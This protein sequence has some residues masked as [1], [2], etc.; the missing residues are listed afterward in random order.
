MPQNHVSPL[1]A[2]LA[3]ARAG[4]TFGEASRSATPRAVGT[5]EHQR[6][7]HLEADR[8]AIAPTGEPEVGRL[9]RYTV[10]TSGSVGE[11]CPYMASGQ[12]VANE[13][14]EIDRLRVRATP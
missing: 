12:T 10:G 8:S 11:E 6:L 4:W 5:R 14:V 3:L 1:S 2:A 7:R 13:R 9:P